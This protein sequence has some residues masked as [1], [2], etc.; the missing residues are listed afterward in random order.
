MSV[1][2]KLDNQIVQRVS[3]EV[4]ISHK[5]VQNVIALVEDGNTVPFIA[6]YRKE[7]TGALDEVQ[8][9]N[10]LDSWNYLMNLEER[11]E[12]VHRLIEEQGKLTEE[13]AAQIHQAKKL[14]QVEDLYRPFKQKRRTKATVAKE[15]GLEPLAQW[16]LSF[17]NSDVNIE[18]QTYINEEAG[19]Q[20]SD[21]AIQGALDIVAEQ[22]SDEASYR[23]WIRTTTVK[24]GIIVTSVKDP[25]K[26]E[27]NIYEMYYE[28]TEA[29]KRIVPHRI[30]AMNRGEKDGILKVS[31]DA[32]TDRIL[33]YLH[34]EVIK[35]RDSSVE[36]YIISAIEDAY[37]RL[38]EPSIER[39]IRK[40]LSEKAEERAI[41]IFS[42]NLRKLLLQPPLK[43]KVVLGVDPAFRTGC[44]LAV[45]DETGK[46]L[47]IDV[48][49]PHPPVR[50][51][52]EAQ[53]KL[54]KMF[55]EYPIEVVAIGNGTASRE[56]EQF[57]ADVLK[58]IE[59][60]VYYLI[61]N[62][63]GAS[64]Y[65]ASD[66]AREEFPD[67]QV[68]ERSAVSIAR[69]LQDP[70]AELVKIDPKSVGV[71]QYQHDVSQKQLNDSLTFI[72]ETVVNQVGV[73]ANTASA[74][75]LQYVAGLNK[76]VAQNIV[77]Y[78]DENGKFSN[79]KQLKKIPRLGAKTYEQCIGFLRII[80]GEEPLD[81]TGIHPE[82]YG[83]VK[84]LLKKAE[85]KETELGTEKVKEAL[86][87][88]SLPEISEELS[89]GELTLKDIIEALVRPERDPRDELPKPL[90]RQD[91]LKLE[92]L[93]KGIQL[94]GT[95]RN[96]VDFGAFIDIGVKQ[97]GLVHISKLTNRYVK[98]PLDVVSVG[99]LV[100]VWVE[101][102]DMKK[103]RVA[104][105]MIP[106][107]Q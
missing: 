1:A 35:K 24:D 46:V 69:R 103:G 39:E 36:G 23:Q 43:G 30:L 92:D 60:P 78:R 90:L 88:I 54:K 56:T 104:L 87:H 31:I 67:F 80:E 68:E 95:V 25:E 77:K 10:I 63:A 82:T 26:D 91:I 99:D 66:V 86:K 89:I 53:N 19:V 51:A 29:V 28:Y 50:K 5:Q 64:V 6:R 9:R 61:V 49:Y 102:V 81:R 72:V 41:H 3:K 11:K 57:V 27:K 44:K 105:T 14:Q 8:I 16:L 12:E 96:V 32:P 101:D 55:A 34:K 93:A 17:P 21:E 37:K 42:E 33:S 98:H 94:E 13:L 2:T 71:G 4:E 45:V 97:D 79:R 38:I 52:A 70:L 22:I 40:D 106:P 62:E 100:N 83:D 58:E 73:N 15:K 65:S 7:Q 76:T 48:I 74:S 84:K 59:N 85:V 18:A 20:S 75:L 47:K 107:H